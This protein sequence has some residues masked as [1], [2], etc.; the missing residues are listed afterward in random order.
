ME[1]LILLENTDIYMLHIYGARRGISQ[2]LLSAGLIADLCG[3]CPYITLW[4][5]NIAREKSMELGSW[6]RIGK[7]GTTSLSG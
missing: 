4:K 1:L 5:N 3:I 6:P 7:A 2:N